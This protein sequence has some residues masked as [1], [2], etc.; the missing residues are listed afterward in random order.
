MFRGLSVIHLDA[1]GRIAIPQRYLEE[2]NE[3]ADGQLVV[4]IDPEQHCLWLYPL[5]AWEELEHK[6]ER[7]PLLH[8]ITKRLQRLL[9]GHAVNVEI[10]KAS[11]VLIPK[12]LM[13]FADLDK[14][15]ILVGQGHYFEIWDEIR[16]QDAREEWLQI[17]L[18]DVDKQ[19]LPQELHHFFV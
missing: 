16:W 6:L 15:V 3:E 4:T 10:Q 18:D 14:R 9:I 19:A 8:P 12:F 5:N 11:R 2:L 17:G 13:E 1:K 7:L